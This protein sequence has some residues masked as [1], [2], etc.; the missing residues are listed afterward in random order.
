MDDPLMVVLR[1]VHI[2]F[3]MFWAGTA[4]FLAVILDPRLR[5]L[6][7]EVQ[8][9]VMGAIAP[10]MGPALGISGILTIGAGIWIAFKVKPSDIWF[11]TGWGYAIATGFVASIISFAF[12]ISTGA[13][14]NKMQALGTAIQGRPPTPEEGAQLKKTGDMLT[15]FGRF[16]AV[17]VVIAVGTMASARWV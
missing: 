8:R 11:D 3:G 6:G 2:V 1:I 10:I 16:T 13:L 7:P 9:P 17:F 5:S 12:G 14:S 15:L 4:V